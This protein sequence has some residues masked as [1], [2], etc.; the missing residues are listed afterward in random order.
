MSK[1]DKKRG[2]LRAWLRRLIALLLNP[3]FL[4]CFGIAWLITNGW[5]YI[6]LGLGI[7]YEIEWMVAVASAYL[8]FLWLPA[9]PEKLLTTSIAI[10]LLRHF[11]PNDEKTLGVLREWHRAARAKLRKRKQQQNDSSQKNEEKDS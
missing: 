9:T 2:R 1:K 10:L 11:F 8:A 7:W 5:A 6:L 3:R 4:L